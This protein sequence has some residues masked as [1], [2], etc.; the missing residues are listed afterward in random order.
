MKNEFIKKIFFNNEKKLIF[1]SYLVIFTVIFYKLKNGIGNIWDW[2]FPYFQDSISNYFFIKYMA[3]T[4]VNLGSALSYS[5]DYFLRFFVS[6]TYFLGINPEHI[7]FIY[8]IVLFSIGSFGVYLIFRK[9]LTNFKS[10]ILGMSVF[11]SPALFYNILGG[12]FNYYFSFVLFIYLIYFLLYYY[13]GTIRETV[14]V[15]IIFSFIGSQIQFFIISFIFIVIYFIFY[16]ERFRKINAM[17]FIF[18]VLLINLPWISNFITGNASIENLSDKANEVSFQNSYQQDSLSIFSLVFS[19]AT[20]IRRFYTLPY[21]LFFILFFVVSLFPLLFKDKDK[22]I[23]SSSLIVFFFLA[24]GYFRNIKI[25]IIYLFY[26]IF[27]QVGHFSSI[28]I[29]LLF[30]IGTYNKKNKNMLNLYLFFAILFILMNSFM[31]INNYPITD[32]SKNRDKFLEFHNFNKLDQTTYRVLNY[33]FFNQYSFLYQNKTDRS[34]FLTSNSGYDSFSIYSG[35]DI[36]NNYVPPH[37]FNKS[38]Q[39][40]FITVNNYS[41]ESLKKYNIKYIYDLSEIYESNY[42][43]FVS[44]ETYNNNL[45]LI[46][47]DPNFVKKIINNNGKKVTLVKP[48]IVR[49]NNFLSRIYSDGSSFKKLN[50][51]KYKIYIENISSQ[52]NLSFLESYHSGWKL[53]LQK[54]PT[55]EWC[56]PIEFYGNTNTTECEHNQRFFEGEEFSYL[57]KEPVFD[58]GHGKVYDYA[59]GWTID[60]EYIMENYSEEY[61]TENPDG[62]INVEMVLYFK[63]QSYFYLGLL[64]SGMTLL[65]CVGYLLYTKMLERRHLGYPKVPER[66]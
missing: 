61:Y 56:E 31:Y 59:N 22:L 26:P 44:K 46:K 11:L 49:L 42:E 33:P 8:L 6:L 54:N 55:D 9:Y 23:F 47:N 48:K 38:I 52:Q 10:C 36:I 53:Y 25:P 35:N 1:F 13:K 20:Q 27:R 58:G 64:I 29:F 7:I 41:V 30:C 32:F 16:K 17:L 12:F 43:R 57:W 62:S 50:P 66:K 24:T 15:A 3:W 21:Q 18:I 37:D 19:K 2:V 4:E 51:T 60:S 34:G 65:G 28:I 5:S 14:F 45:A 63:P 39:Y 40:L